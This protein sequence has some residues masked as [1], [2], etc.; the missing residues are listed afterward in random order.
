MAQL[1]QKVVLALVVTTLLLT[2]INISH[3]STILLPRHI[4][5][6]DKHFFFELLSQ[7][8]PVVRHRALVQPTPSPSSSSLSSSQSLAQPTIEA[9]QL[10]G[11]R[12]SQYKPELASEFTD[13]ADRVLLV[14]Y[15]VERFA[16]STFLQFSCREQRTYQLLP[17]NKITTK[18]CVDA[19]GGGT[20][21][22][23]PIRFIA[24][25]VISR[26]Q[27]ASSSSSS[28]SSSSFS[29]SSSGS[30]GESSAG[31][32][33]RGYDVI[34][35]ETRH[36]SLSITLI[37]NLLS[38]IAAGG[39]LILTDTT[40]LQ[41]SW[42]EVAILRQ[43]EWLDCATLDADY[44][45]TIV[46]RRRNQ[47]PLDL[48]FSATRATGVF[49]SSSN[50]NNNTATI[51]SDTTSL[52]G[53]PAGREELAATTQQEA[54]SLT[55]DRFKTEKQRV[56]NLLSFEDLHKWLAPDTGNV[57][58]LTAFGG[59]KGLAAYHEA[60][61]YRNRCSAMLASTEG[62]D[63]DKALSCFN[64]AMTA[65]RLSP[66]GR[67]QFAMLLMSKAML[68]EAVTMLGELQAISP[69]F[70]KWVILETSLQLTQR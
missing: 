44:G 12:R 55:F 1:A 33:Q 60:L 63:T 39:V 62:S 51:S 6:V 4:K 32:R 43:R 23:D 15:L 20:H 57:D 47:S 50:S 61:E 8:D 27:A 18:L 14:Q 46:T 58:L 68:V 9:V 65:G 26:G 22:L 17:D 2:F 53:G 67:W 36:L 16:Y 59:K 49:V 56:L 38:I 29:S 48:R 13:V 54:K 41:S 40:D 30:I 3:V 25:T 7:H 45:I 21:T 5:R 24:D 28:S 37:D 34:L 64:D 70:Y 31:A 42:R 35:V 69:A 19:V 10:W 11:A 52:G 66:M